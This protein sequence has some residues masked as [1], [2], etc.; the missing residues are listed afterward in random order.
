MWTSTIAQSVLESLGQERRRVTST[1]RTLILARRISASEGAPLPPVVK[2]EQIV[3][4][5]VSSGAIEPIDGVQSVYKVMVP[6]ANLLPVATEHIAQ[7]ANPAAVFCHWTALSIHGLTQEIP[8]TIF[9]YHYKN[10][11]HDRI[12]LGTTPEDWLDLERPRNALPLRVEGTSID[13][14]RSAAD[15]DFGHSV[16]TFAGLPIYVTDLE[17]T[18][19]DALRFPEKAGGILNALRAWRSAR[20]RLSPGTIVQYVERFESSVLSQR[21]G[22]ILEE[23]KLEH[24]RL[25]QWRS[26]L[27][28]G[29]SMKLV[30]SRPYAPTYSDRWNLSIN[31]PDEV[32]AELKNE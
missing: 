9:A 8:D 30:A 7:E 32:I 11:S 15:R 31:V 13:W 16:A 4:H 12:P 5:L 23:L 19:L 3:R 14:T 2:A 10:S 24:P 28:R 20:D 26:D 22:Y 25:S 27:N 17:R 29:G 18:L 21:A 6:F 1:W